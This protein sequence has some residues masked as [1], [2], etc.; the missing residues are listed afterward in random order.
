[1]GGTSLNA[2]DPNHKVTTNDETTETGLMKSMK[3]MH[4]GDRGSD[5]G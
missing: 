2:D 3:P 5:F 1:M 4:M